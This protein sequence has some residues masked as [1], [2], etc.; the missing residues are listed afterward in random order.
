MLE[1]LVTADLPADGL[2]LGLFPPGPVLLQAYEGA[3]CGA[4][5]DSAYAGIALR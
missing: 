3:V 4:V 5:P 1:E 2:G